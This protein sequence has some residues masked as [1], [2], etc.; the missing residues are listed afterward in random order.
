ML[1]ET[2]RG[3]SGKL[4]H[5]RPRQI[6][7]AYQP[8][9]LRVGAVIL[10][11]VQWSRTVKRG[12]PQRQVRRSGTVPGPATAAQSVAYSALQTN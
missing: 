12:S 5:G 1:G 7:V 4:P 6:L 8:S 2:V 10:L 3:L 11:S 9:N